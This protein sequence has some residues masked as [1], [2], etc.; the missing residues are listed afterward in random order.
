MF[1]MNPMICIWLLFIIAFVAVEVA[2]VGLTSIWFAA[3]AFCSLIIAIIHGPVWLQIVVFLVVS[4]ALLAGTRSW[5]NRFINRNTQS[6]NVDSLIGEEIRIAERV[7]NLD[8]TG[9]AVVR[10]QEWTVRAMT[11]GEIFAQGELARVAG[12]SGVKLMVEK[13]VPKQNEEE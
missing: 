5:A 3:G 11:D 8:Q 13:I 10:G 9:T 1:G 2:T 12:V 6:T 4:L 7:S